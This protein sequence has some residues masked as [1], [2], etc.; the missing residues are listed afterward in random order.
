MEVGLGPHHDGRSGSGQDGLLIIEGPA[1]LDAQ[2]RQVGRGQVPPTH[3]HAEALDPVGRVAEA[4]GVSQSD[5]P[6]VEVEIGLDRVPGG[7]WLLGHEGSLDSEQGVEERR[8][9]GVGT[10]G[11]HHQRAPSHPL[12]QMGRSEQAVDSRPDRSKKR[13]NGLSVDGPVV[14]LREVDVIAEERQQVHQLLAKVGQP[15]RKPAVELTKR[16]TPLGPRGGIDQIADRLRLNQIELA[17]Q[18]RA[19]GELTRRGRPGPGRVKCGHQLARHEEAPVT[20]ELHQILAGVAAGAG[21]KGDQPPVDRG[22]VAFVECREDGP[23]GEDRWVLIPSE[24]P[25]G[26]DEGVAAREAND[27]QRGTT[28]SRRDGGDEIGQHGEGN[29][30]ATARRLLLARP[31]RR[32][33]RRY[34]AGQ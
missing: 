12:P 34:R 25:P 14:L 4:G 29:R 3:R 23:A 30:P 18:N 1:S 24:H 6:P 11:Q 9:P 27:R 33:G 22:A 28:R 15:P 32:S 16:A 26:R 20:A 10:T 19:A 31:L 7:S 8:L 2:E 21:E 17:V 5:R 13:L